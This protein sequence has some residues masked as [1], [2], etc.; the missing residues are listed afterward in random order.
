[1]T[2]HDDQL[3]ADLERKA[4]ELRLRVLDMV[5]TAQSGHLGGSFSAAEIL[6]SLYLHHLRI[7]ASRPDWED[8]DRFLLSKGHAAP[9]LYCALAA[10]GFFP[11]EELGTFRH[12]GSRL[13]GHPERGHTPG[14]EMTSGPLGHGIGVGIGMALAG[15][16]G[17]KGWRVYVLVGDGEMQAG[18][19]WEAAMAAAKY[20]LANLTVIVDCNGVQLDGPV[21]EIMPLEPI[22]EKWSAFGWHVRE[23]NGHSVREL[24]DA[25]D[26]SSDIC[27]GPSA[28]IAHTVKGM[29]V[30]FM[31]HQSSWH[32]K[33]PSSEEYLLAAGELRARL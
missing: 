27:R 31:E 25:L 2:H 11:S 15:R 20:H 26:K 7:D 30:S 14:V 9:M 4:N 28:I 1:M 16:L 17:G 22:V 5:Q 33:V 23:V 29:G 18:A 19:I 32:G 10:A 24:L 8:R 12:L 3:V 6:T 21:R 13:S